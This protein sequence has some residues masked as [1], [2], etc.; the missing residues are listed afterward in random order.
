MKIEWNE[1]KNISKVSL[2]TP[3]KENHHFGYSINNDLYYEI[4]VGFQEH[5]DEMCTLKKC[6]NHWIFSNSNYDN[7]LT[8]RLNKI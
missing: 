6:P 4:N 2:Y 7:V 8:W 5:G 3:K 1:L